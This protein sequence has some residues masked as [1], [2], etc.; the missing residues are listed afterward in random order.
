MTTPPPSGGTVVCGV[1]SKK[2]QEYLY[3]SLQ[4]G[5]N[6]YMTNKR[7]HTI[8]DLED[9]KVVARLVDATLRIYN[10][11]NLMDFYDDEEDDENYAL[12][13]EEYHL[14]R[15]AEDALGDLIADYI[16]KNARALINEMNAK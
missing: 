13:V 5:D 4:L 15:A 14:A 9:E 6:K 3:F 10:G 7:Y 12:S 1:V 16:N 2:C 11:E 8:P